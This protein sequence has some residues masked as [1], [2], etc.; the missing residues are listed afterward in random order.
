MSNDRIGT[1]HLAGEAAVGFARSFFNPSAD[2]IVEQ[3]MRRNKLNSNI[4][5]RKNDSGFEAEIDGLDLSFLEEETKEEQLVITVK[6]SVRPQMSIF[7]NSNQS[8]RYSKVTFSPESNE[9]TTCK[10]TEIINI[11][12]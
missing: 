11:A 2:E 1:L 9:F 3:E 7:Y 10:T 8:E 12:A 4:S 6:L 5:V